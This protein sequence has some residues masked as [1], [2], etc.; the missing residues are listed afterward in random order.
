MTQF[1][2]GIVVVHKKD[3]SITG[4][5]IDVNGI[6]SVRCRIANSRPVTTPPVS[7]EELA[8]HFRV[9]T[10]EEALSYVRGGN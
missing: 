10:E 3:D 9:A 7:S 4:V 2:S 1:E 8:E 5:V 6:Y